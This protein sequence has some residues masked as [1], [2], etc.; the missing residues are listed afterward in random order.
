MDNLHRSFL[1]NSLY[2]S[3]HEKAHH[4][5]V[6]WLL[7]FFISCLAASSLFTA[8]HKADADSMMML[9]NPISVG[10]AGSL[11]HWLMYHSEDSP[12]GMLP[13]TLPN[14]P[15]SPL[16]EWV[17]D[18]ANNYNKLAAPGT[19]SS[20]WTTASTTPGPSDVV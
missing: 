17:P 3:W 9:G 5:L 14:L 13:T 6:H 7:F 19:W 2:S 8:I 16:K 1:S 11:P 4:K 18:L 20:N 15:A 10:P 12:G